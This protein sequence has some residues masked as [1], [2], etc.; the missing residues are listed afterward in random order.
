MGAERDAFLC[1]AVGD[2]AG[3]TILDLGC[4]AGA[5]AEMVDRAMGRPQRYVGIDLIEDRIDLARKR[6]PWGEF[7]VASADRLPLEDRSIDVVIA[8]TLF[9]SLPEAWFRLEVAHE[10]D[11]VLAS[12]GRLVIYDL[13]YPSPGN[14][15]VVPIRRAELETMFPG[16]RIE[17]R[18]LTLLPP[19]ARSPIG[20]GE[21]RYRA[22]VRVPLLRSHIGA[23]LT[24]G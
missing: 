4:G 16:W 6:V 8:A 13:R 10:I 1:R 17:T 19:L 7:H 2:F 18:T 22:L 21:R 11:R 12:D 20:S 15:A 5:F 14:R 24:R 3:R 23:V 9:S